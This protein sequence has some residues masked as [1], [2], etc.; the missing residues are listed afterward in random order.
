MLR[1]HFLNEPVFIGRNTLP[2]RN[3]STVNF[4]HSSI[5]RTQ[6]AALAGHC[7]IKMT[8]RYVHLASS[9]LRAESEAVEQRNPRQ[10]TG[11][12]LSTDTRGTPVSR[13]WA[14]EHISAGVPNG[15]FQRGGRFPLLL[16]DR[17][18]CLCCLVGHHLKSPKRWIQAR[19]D[20]AKVSPFLNQ[21]Q[22]VSPFLLIRYV[23]S[24]VWLNEGMNR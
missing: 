14:G 4:I 16:L 22:C 23:I 1:I 13:E 9:H 10:Q 19:L 18:S 21:N 2:A 15:I 5:I 12:A 17:G 6:V 7:D 11:L 8:L 3:H 24:S 20:F